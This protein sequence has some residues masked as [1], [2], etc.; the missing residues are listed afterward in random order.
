MT[1]TPP[2][3][4]FVP[5]RPNL[6]ALG[7]LSIFIVIL[8]LPMLSGQWL[9]APYGDQ[10]SS[11]YAFYAWEATE[12][13]SAGS[14]PLW[15][16]MIMGGLPFI[17]VVT[18]GEILYPTALLRAFLPV[19]VVMN[20]AFFIH[21]ILAG[22]FTYLFLRRLAVSWTG[23]VT[24]ALAYQLS[25][26]LI[27]LVQPGHPG[28]LFVS[29]LLPLTLLALVVALRERR[30]W[31]YPLLAVAVGL[32]LLS[33][34]VQATYYLLIAAALFAVYLTFGETSTEPM[35]PR[36][37]RLGVTLAAV[38]A[39][40]G[41]AAPQIL[42]FLEYIPHSPRATAY[43]VGYAGSTSYGIPWDH[44]PEFFLAGFTGAPEA[45]WGSNPLKHHSEY[46]GLPV[47]ALAILGFGDRRRRLVWW[48]G[49]IGLL[50]LLIA[51]GGATP[52]YHLWWAVMP[53]VKKTR[54]PGMV[55]FV[56]AFCTAMFAAFGVTR[57][58]REGQGLWRHVRA[59]LIAA[60]A[61]AVLGVVGAFGRFAL[62][63]APPERV[64]DAAAHG[65]A[66]R[67]AAVVGAIM[68]AAIALLI[69]GRLLGKVPAL[70]FAVGLPLMVGVDLWRDGRRFWT[71]SPPPH[72]GLYRTDDV[73]ERL[74][75]APKP[76]RVFNLNVY[77]QN[78]LMAHGIP[79]VLGYQGNELRYYDELLG[80]RNVWQYLLTSPRLWELLAV[81]YVVLPD[82][83]GL[84]GY[85]LALG[86]VSTAAGTRAFV[87][88]ADTVPPYARVVPG[89]AK[90]DAGAIPP[91]LSD[92]RL[93]G[94]DRV[95]FF[96]SD[97]PINPLPL[98]DWPPPSSSTARVTAWA[99]GKMTI[100]L[101]PPPRDSSY[102][103]VAENWYVDWRATVDGRPAPVLRGD[104]ALI[105]VP[106]PAGTRTV[107]LSY[108]SRTFARGKLIA[109]V[110]LI[111]V[112]AG[113]VV[114][115]V[116]ARKRRG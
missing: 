45:Y 27:S 102:V 9:A 35:R 116:L 103:L 25:G 13:R 73:I 91:T 60:G 101:D 37:T 100:A 12:W 81:R 95:V 19:H 77:P 111:V 74:K 32:C 22:Y 82:T 78:V 79:Q 7:I 88:E 80:G 49:G 86:P 56:V 46:L 42:P 62:A 96:A 11:A 108:Y 97:A 21:Y 109:L 28:K 98:Q 26:I 51:L 76:L 94:Y 36:L 2:V 107:E 41:I 75:Q 31:G 106:V 3:A 110:T 24:G 57:L 18:H 34:H 92:P 69:W 90:V 4:A 64:A 17:A 23:A 20:L 59:W 72:Q 115:P 63:I 104:H 89:A 33:P 105:T 48:M 66:I 87:Y 65:D 85:H 61:I 40:F 30:V 44:V 15:N 1:T 84:P 58:E 54:A 39:G 5:A 50:F 53:M 67:L 14:L 52:F 71:Y 16:P 70:A 10:Y 99:A 113:L 93:P 43:S 83:A 47:I 68:F 114:P 112:L 38:I 29:A 8:S 55:F 6:V